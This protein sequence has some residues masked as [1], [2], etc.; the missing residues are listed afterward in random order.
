MGAARHVPLRRATGAI[1]TTAHVLLPSAFG[2]QGTKLVGT[3]KHSGQRKTLS[4]SV[5][6]T[7]RQRVT[8]ARPD[9]QWSADTPALVARQLLDTSAAQHV[10]TPTSLAT[11]HATTATPRL[12][13]DAVRTVL[14]SPDGGALIRLVLGQCA[15]SDAATERLSGMKRALRISVTTATWLRATAAQLRAELSAD[16]PALV[17]RQLQDTSAAQHAETPSSLATRHATTATPRLE[18]DAVGP[19]NRSSDG[20]AQLSRAVGLIAR[21]SA[22]TVSRP[23]QKDAMTATRQRATAAAQGAQS[24]ADTTALLHSPTSAARH[25]ETPGALARR[26]ATTATPSVGMDAVRIAQMLRPDG[27]AQLSRVVGLIA[28]KYVETASR[29]L[30][31]GAMTATRQRA[32]AAAQYAQSS[33][34]TIAMDSRLCVPLRH[35]VTENVQALNHATMEA[36]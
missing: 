35:A 28:R 2:R 11:R 20:I 15:Q 24:S 1:T 4:I 19:A 8:A 34:D 21:K 22:E 25:A 16:T 10:V 36:P 6:I 27:L 12:V 33:A 26:H 30:Q 13:M 18:M 17:A 32:T 9:A 31:K 5:T 7:T 29:P 14:L 3:A 23:L